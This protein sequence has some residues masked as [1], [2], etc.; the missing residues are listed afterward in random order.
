MNGPPRNIWSCSVMMLGYA[1]HMGWITKEEA[2]ETLRADRVWADARA[3]ARELRAAGALRAIRNSEI[4]G[5]A[6][7]PN[8]VSS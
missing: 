1:E 3:K 2:E 4:S 7:T 5:L 6:S 8:G